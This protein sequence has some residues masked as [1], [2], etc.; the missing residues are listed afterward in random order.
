VKKLALGALLIA[1]LTVAA[2]AGADHGALSAREY[3]VQL[4]RI[5]ANLTTRYAAIGEPKSVEQLGERGAQFVA[6]FEDALAALK[7]LRPPA[8]LRASADRFV[9]V[10]VKIRDALDGAF[11]AARMKDF[12]TLSKFGAVIDP[13][14]KETDSI[15]NRLGA[16]AC[17][18]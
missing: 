6:A 15:A 3:R 1:V 17:A 10:S 11:E 13:L 7:T 12:A 2:W 4:N 5:C 14:D 9:A 8:E 18:N 16:P